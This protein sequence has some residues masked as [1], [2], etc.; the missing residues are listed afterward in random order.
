MADQASRRMPFHMADTSSGV[1]YELSVTRV[2]VQRPSGCDVK[3]Q[4][5]SIWTLSNAK[6]TFGAG[7]PSQAIHYRAWV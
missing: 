7:L 1:P 2:A 5:R 4:L 3:Q 6:S